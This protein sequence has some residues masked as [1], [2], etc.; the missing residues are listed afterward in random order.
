MTRIALFTGATILAKGLDSIL[1]HDGTFELLPPCSSLDRLQA[2]VE[3]DAPGIILLD[4][5]LDVNLDVVREIRGKAPAAKLV[6]W[7]DSISPEMAM[8]TVRLG[9]RG[10][11]RKRLPVDLH[12]KCLHHVRSG[13]VWFEKALTEPSATP[14]RIVLTGLEEQLMSLLAQGFKNS[15]IAGSLAIPE[16][17]VK[18]YLPQLY[19]KLGVKDRFELALYGL[20][21]FGPKSSAASPA[22]AQRSAPTDEARPE[23]SVAKGMPVPLLPTL[24]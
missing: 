12:L 4:Y 7:V 6:L 17:T 20:K 3:K 2:Q 19:Q 23:E 21:H 1:R 8:Q 9:I 16:S 11:L 18:T 22:P 14:S 13:E 5:S 10:I 24:Q 15:E